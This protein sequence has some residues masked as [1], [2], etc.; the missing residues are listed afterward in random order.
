MLLSYFVVNLPIP[1][2]S[3]PSGTF[4]AGHVDGRGAGGGHHQ[5]Q[6][7]PHPHP[8]NHHHTHHH[9]HRHQVNS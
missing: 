4:Q 8:H 3:S 1:E 9:N 7:Q 5:L 2:T 6:A